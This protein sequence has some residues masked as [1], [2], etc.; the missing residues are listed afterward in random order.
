MWMALW[1]GKMKWILYSDWLRTWAHKVGLSCQLGIACF[2]PTKVKSFGVI[3][4]PYDK[5]FIDQTCLV[6]ITLYWPSPLFVFLL[7]S[8]LCWS[9]IQTWKMNKANILPSWLRT[10]SITETC[11]SSN[12]FTILI[13]KNASL[14]LTSLQPLLFQRKYRNMY[15]LQLMLQFSSIR[16]IWKKLLK[17]TLWTRL[18]EFSFLFMT[19]TQGLFI[20]LER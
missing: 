7:T 3:F 18:L 16:E 14:V 13:R 11:M 1:V 10:W 6:K 15:I 5:S 19:M 2:V 20:L 12:K 4:W 8:S 17:L 9:I